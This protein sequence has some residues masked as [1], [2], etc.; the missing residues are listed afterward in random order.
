[1]QKMEPF[2]DLMAESPVVQK[3]LAAAMAE[4][5]AKG[6]VKGRA[7]GRIETLQDAILKIVKARFPRLT[8]VARQYVREVTKLE[9]LDELF[10]A[11]LIAADEQAALLAFVDLES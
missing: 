10:N 8:K 9:E 4:G 3:V 6:E 7:E 5:E 1:M 2:A 11:L